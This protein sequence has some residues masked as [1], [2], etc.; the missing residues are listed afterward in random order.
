M[1]LRTPKILK[2]VH[3]RNQ[4]KQLR[5]LIDSVPYVH[6]KQNSKQDK[7]PVNNSSFLLNCL[8]V[9]RMTDSISTNA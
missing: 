1:L 7:T 6:Q 3:D 9:N 4:Y 2:A 5:I 8:H